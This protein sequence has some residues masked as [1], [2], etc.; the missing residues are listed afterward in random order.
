MLDERNKV[1][2]GEDNKNNNKLRFYSTVKGCFKKEPYLD[3]VPNRAQ[4]ADLTRFLIS[5]SRL[6]IEVQ[7]YKRPKVPEIERYCMYCMPTSP[8][9]NIEGYIDNEEHFLTVCSTFTL[10]RNCLY[11]RMDSLSSGFGS[12]SPAQQS[13]LLLCSTSILGAKYWGDQ[14]HP[15]EKIQALVII[16]A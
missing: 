4:R 8:D 13:V 12:L 2:L 5:S 1:K 6:A 15:A 16:I 14:L 9:N 11:T 3:L 7:R 10:G